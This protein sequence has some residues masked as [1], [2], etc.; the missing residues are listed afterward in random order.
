MSD[1]VL[2][3]VVEKHMETL[4]HNVLILSFIVYW[5]VNDMRDEYFSF[6]YNIHFIPMIM[7]SF[8]SCGP[9]LKLI[10]I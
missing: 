4:L 1:R 2:G 7:N 9:N 6:L 10:S 3:Q 8:F 5:A